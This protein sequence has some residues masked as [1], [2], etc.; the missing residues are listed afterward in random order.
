M[1]TERIDIADGHIELTYTSPDTVATLNIV[2]PG[3][4]CERN[5]TEE[6]VAR[7]AEHL[8]HIANRMKMHRA[9]R[10]LRIG[11]PK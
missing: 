9:A 4:D 5:L 3:D 8:S 2:S 11:R 1:I 6:Q 10:A 7:L